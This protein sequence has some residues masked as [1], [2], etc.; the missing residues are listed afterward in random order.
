MEMLVAIALITVTLIPA[1]DSLQSGIQ[2][3]GIYSAETDSHYW[4]RSKVDELMAM[5]YSML[6]EQATDIDDPLNIEDNLSDALG[7]DKCRLVYL[8]HYDGDNKDGD[9]DPFTGVDHGLLWIRV[10]LAGQH[11][12]LETLIRR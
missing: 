12:F 4:L 2:G 10:E 9:N 5:N 8:A 3:S 6:V 7:S 11:H 1:L